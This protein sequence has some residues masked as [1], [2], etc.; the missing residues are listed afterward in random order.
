MFMKTLFTYRGDGKRAWKE[1]A[2]GTRTY[3]YYAGQQMIAISNGTNAST[4]LLW[5]ADGLIGMRSSV[6]GALTKR[7]QLYDTQGNL[8]QTLDGNGAVTGQAAFSAWGEPLRDAAGNQAL[9]G[10]FGYGAKF[11]YWR[12]GE[13]GFVLCTLRYYDPSGGR[14]IT[15]DPIGY[16]GGSNLYGYVGGDPVNSTDPSGLAG[17]KFGGD[18]GLFIGWG[19]PTFIL[20]PDDFHAPGSIGGNILS[21]YS[22]S[23]APAIQAGINT[24]GDWFYNDS[25]VRGAYGE[26]AP[27]KKLF[28]KIQPRFTGGWTVDNGWA[29]SCSGSYSKAGDDGNKAGGSYGRGWTEDGG[30]NIKNSRPGYG[31]TIHPDIQSKFTPVFQM[32]TSEPLSPGKTRWRLGVRDTREKGTGLG[33][34]VIFG[35]PPSMK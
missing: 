4:L 34:G 25:P 26:W 30:W 35:L 24:K 16:A 14:W 21:G 12:D 11:G 3:F 31:V 13:S 17:V 32:N 2:N 10:A 33:G 7:Y 5:G 8:A 19:E 28:N 20:D 18:D 15:R 6:N 23:S 1:L 9:A 22:G 27:K 29:F